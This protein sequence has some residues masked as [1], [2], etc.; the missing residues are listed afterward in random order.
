MF[1]N[2]LHKFL[3]CERAALGPA[4]PRPRSSTLKD[5]TL[6]TPHLFFHRW[7][8]SPIQF[9]PNPFNAL[10]T[11]VLCSPILLLTRHLTAFLSIAFALTYQ[12][13]CTLPF[14]DDINLPSS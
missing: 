5:F 2:K 14:Q 10:N 11:V 7:D 3:P 8:C 12:D 9:Q 1:S 4:E 6:G 13:F